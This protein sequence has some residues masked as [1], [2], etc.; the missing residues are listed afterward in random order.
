MP[1]RTGVITDNLAG[2][3]LVIVDGREDITISR[4]G[5]SVRA[6]HWVAERALG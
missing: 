5:E 1:Q 4:G 3:A 6:P 2:D